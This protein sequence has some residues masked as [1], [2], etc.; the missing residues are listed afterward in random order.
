MEVNSA[1]VLKN[2]KNIQGLAK[3]ASR[4]SI[5]TMA[6]PGMFQY[7]VIMSNAISTDAQMAIA[8]AYQ[9]TFAGS[10][11]TAFSLNP[12]MDRGKTPQL[13]E[14][15]QT[16]HQNDP[17]LL[18]GNVTGAAQALGVSIEQSMENIDPEN[19]SVESATVAKLNKIDSLAMNLALKGVESSLC[20]ES[21][22][23]MYTPYDRTERIIRERLDAIK[24]VKA[25]R[26]LEGDLFD[27]VDAKGNI[28]EG[29]IGK[30]N[31]VLNGA[32][33]AKAATGIRN[34]GKD[35]R[36]GNILPVNAKY[37]V[38]KNSQ[39]EA[40][41]PTMVNV[42]VVAHGGR[43][44]NGSE[45]PSIHNITLGVKAMPR[46]IDT[47]LMI[48]SMVEA[49]QD[50]RMIFK[51]LKWTKGEQSTLDYILGFSASKKKALQKNAKMEVKFLEQSKKRKKLNGIGRFLNNEVLP[52]VSVVITA[53]EASKIK[54]ICGID[55][56]NYT[57]AVK[58]MNQYY[59]LSFAIFD[60]EMNTLKVIFDCDG[61]WSYTTIGA[62]KSQIGKT[63]YD[64]LADNIV[65]SIFNRR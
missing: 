28:K 45:L 12:I 3:L 30:L 43:D 29:G 51:F 59:L 62:I 15:V 53:Y 55:L 56:N 6:A 58:L 50:S 35:G 2:V 23:D 48:A 40:M 16:F 4:K 25:K 42:Q 44:A 38:E 34:P 5:M 47:N 9:L 7:P 36:P 19:I 49:S 1:T 33:N 27:K 14:F 22:N 65:R 21:M 31:R 8:K 60:T 37:S 64:L 24:D 13:S 41:E 46:V 10:V 11:C 20:M 57:D 18:G 39:L 63:N 61:D 54:E 17:T 32:D 26:A 52:T